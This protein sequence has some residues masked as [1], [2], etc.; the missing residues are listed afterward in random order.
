MITTYRIE[1]IGSYLNP[2]E[3]LERAYESRIRLVA[4]NNRSIECLSPGLASDIACSEALYR[5][6]VPGYSKAQAVSLVTDVLEEA[7]GEYED[8]ILD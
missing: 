7:A 2:Y 3:V 4:I 8:G 1:K 5:F 6:L